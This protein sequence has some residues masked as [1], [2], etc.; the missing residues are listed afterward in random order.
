MKII[1]VSKGGIISIIC[2]LKSMNSSGMLKLCSVA[3]SELF[4]IFATCLL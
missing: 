1:P 2:S 4:L 3:I